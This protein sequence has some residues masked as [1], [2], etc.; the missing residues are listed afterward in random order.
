MWYVYLSICGYLIY[1]MLKS[2]YGYLFFF[3]DSLGRSVDIIQSEMILMD[4]DVFVI[5]N[6][7]GDDLY[8]VKLLVSVME[9][10]FY[11]LRLFVF[12]C[13]YVCEDYYVFVDFIQNK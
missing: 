11:S 12:W 2:R 5:Y 7:V 1:F 13:D 10:L 9:V 6:F 4:Y 8:F 3:F